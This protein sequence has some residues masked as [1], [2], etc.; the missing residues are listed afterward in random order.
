[1][2]CFPLLPILTPLLLLQHLMSAHGHGIGFSH[3]DILHGYGG[4]SISV[5]LGLCLCIGIR[6]LE[7][8]HLV[9]RLG[10]RLENLVHIP[11]NS[12]HEI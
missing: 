12:V 5:M 3:T 8:I 6:K 2:R 4:R 1:M 11:R 9:R 7:D 10:R